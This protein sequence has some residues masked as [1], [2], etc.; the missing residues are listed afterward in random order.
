MTAITYTIRVNGVATLLLVA[1]LPTAADGSN[2]ATT[3]A[4]AAGD[5]IDIQVTKAAIGASP[6]GITATME[7]V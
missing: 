1:I 3:I 4:V 2:L 5:L 7:Y 6:V